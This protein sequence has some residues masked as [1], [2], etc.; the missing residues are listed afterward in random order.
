MLLQG[1]SSSEMLKEFLQIRLETIK[2]TARE[3]S[4]TKLQVQHLLQLLVSTLSAVHALFIGSS[5]SILKGF[6]TPLR[7]FI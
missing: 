7:F 3:Q 4:S 2:S 1:K 5:V 6:E